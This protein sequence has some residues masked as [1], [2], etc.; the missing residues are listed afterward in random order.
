M[1]SIVQRSD[2]FHN[3]QPFKI[4]CELNGDATLKSFIIN[5]KH[6][7]TK[8]STSKHLKDSDIAPYKTSLEACFTRLESSGSSFII[9]RNPLD[10]SFHLK[11]QS[12]VSRYFSHSIQL[13]PEVAKKI[14]E[15]SMQIQN[16][17]EAN[18]IFGKTKT[19]NIK[20]LDTKPNT[21]EKTTK[22]LMLLLVLGFFAGV[23]GLGAFLPQVGA[24]STSL[25]I[26]GIPMAASIPM[27]VIGFATIASYIGLR[28]KAKVSGGKAKEYLED[29]HLKK[30]KWFL[31]SNLNDIAGGL[32]FVFMAMTFIHAPWMVT[33][34][35]CLAY[36][37][38]I[39]LV[40]SGVYQLFESIKALNNAR[41]VGDKKEAIKEV[42]NILTGITLAGIGFFTII[43]MV[44]APVS[45]VLN[46]I[47]GGLTVAV[48][49]WGMQSSY[50]LLKE[51]NKVDE[52]D[53]DA[54][55]K[56]LKDSLT[57]NEKEIDEI[58]TSTAQMKKEDILKWI[59]NNYKTWEK[60]Q[61]EIWDQIKEKLETDKEIEITEIHK[62]IINQEIKNAIERKLETFS[63]VVNE[64]TFR[65]ALHAVD[66]YRDNP[67]VHAKELKELFAKA[68]SEIKCKTIVEF[69][70]FFV[71]FIPMTLA[72]MLHMYHKIGT[73]AYDYAM[74]AL[75][76]LSL[77]INITPRFRNVP[78]TT[79][80]KALDINDEL[81]AYKPL[82]LEAHKVDQLATGIL[83]KKAA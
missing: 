22:L 26:A 9:E 47:A 36:P 48:A 45:I 17:A 34:Q 40:G 59:K 56:F 53:P 3:S 79:L 82:K 67:R 49:G 63:S 1:A 32:L 81:G 35:G 21:N 12:R 76:F 64:D 60:D 50:K 72:P 62:L 38:G 52:N 25:G 23:I 69:V 51:L 75:L 66:K 8:G 20:R 33:L 31:E 44:N 54:I 28:I 77:G 16:T 61:Q 65:K 7:I 19:H 30:S 80:K 46:L 18:R 43:G 6:F 13:S 15:H 78:P 37:A 71:L 29:I 55:M 39:L 74:A 14:H 73:R 68:K 5:N 11:P 58:K 4:E 57:L 70:K 83:H 42:L 2:S 24:I 27:M 10:G 41:Q